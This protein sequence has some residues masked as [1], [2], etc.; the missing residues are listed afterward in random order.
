MMDTLIQLIQ[1]LFSWQFVTI[2]LA[3][4]TIV[5]VLRKV[6]EYLME[7]FAIFSKESKLWNDLVLPIC[8]YFVGPL[9][10]IALTTLPYPAGL[11]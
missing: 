10:A 7:T 9:L 11:V 5:L 1:I 4:Y 2:G 8:P 3:T 6:L